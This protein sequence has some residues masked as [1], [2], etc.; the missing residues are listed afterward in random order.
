MPNLSAGKSA[1][2]RSHQDISIIIIF[3]SF[4]WYDDEILFTQ[5]MNILIPPE[6][7]CNSSKDKKRNL[8]TTHNLNHNHN[9][10]NHE[11]WHKKNTKALYWFHWKIFLWKCRR[12]SIQNHIFFSHL[13]IS[14]LWTADKRQKD[15]NKIFFVW[16]IQIN[17]E[18]DNLPRSMT[19]EIRKRDPTKRPPSCWDLSF[20]FVLAFRDSI[21]Q[22]NSCSNG[23]NVGNLCQTVR[24]MR[25]VMFKKKRKI[26]TQKVYGKHP[27]IIIF[28]GKSF[29]YALNG[30]V[31]LVFNKLHCRADSKGNKCGRMCDVRV[32]RNQGDVIMVLYQRIYFIIIIVGIYFRF[33]SVYA[34]VRVCVCARPW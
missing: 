33:V 6:Y 15:T 19:N 2:Q 12:K 30:N 31:N 13:V 24:I 22:L 32:E 27:H 4:R 25:I 8:Q 16:N 18:E 29:L 5:H 34:C 17:I 28:R 23:W 11:D 3:I 26:I 21:F 1:E 9:H 14:I 10:N 7:R 20:L